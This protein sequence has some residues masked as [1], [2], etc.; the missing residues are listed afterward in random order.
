MET[1]T[2]QTAGAARRERDQEAE[3]ARCALLGRLGP[4]LRHQMVVH[5][6]PVEMIVELARRRLASEQVDLA[7]I[8]EAIDKVD[9]F[10][11]TA[12]IACI[13]SVSWLSEEDDSTITLGE[14]IDECVAV[15]K[16]GLGFRGFALHS[17]V[18]HQAETVS[19]SA[20]RNLLAMAAL[21]LSD[22]LQAPFEITITAVVRASEAVI[23][24][25][26]MP[27]LAAGTF[28]NEK[29]T[30]VLDWGDVR[31]L[32]RAEGA[33]VECQDRLMTICLPLA[34]HPGM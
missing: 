22:T 11:R 3:A 7:L 9:Q 26:A 29:P 24:V 20:L 34:A 2:R 32:A 10:S 6:Q 21:C 5:L 27:S 16:S 18:E 17:A 8:R 30:R 15:L 12:R 4:G 31:A 14:G 25:R 19:R 28:F 33:V 23:Q 13:N 1:N